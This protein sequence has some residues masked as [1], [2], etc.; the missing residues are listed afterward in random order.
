MSP[1]GVVWCG[2]CLLRRLAIVLAWH[3]MCAQTAFVAPVSRLVTADLWHLA[4]AQTARHTVATVAV[5]RPRKLPRMAASWTARRMV[6][7]VY[8]SI[9]TPQSPHQKRRHRSLNDGKASCINMNRWNASQMPAD[10]RLFR[11]PAFP[12]LEAIRYSKSPLSPLI[13]DGHSRPAFSQTSLISL[14]CH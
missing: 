8:Y 6:I 5:R 4:C 1:C 2:F 12:R 14:V 3:L 9:C 7:C 11:K 10:T 13:S